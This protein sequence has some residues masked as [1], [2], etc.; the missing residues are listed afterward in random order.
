MSFGTA[1]RT[2]PLW[3][4]LSCTVILL[5]VACKRP[6]LSSFVLSM[7]HHVTRIQIDGR[8]S[9]TPLFLPYLLAPARQ[10]FGMAPRERARDLEKKRDCSQRV[11][12]FVRRKS[13]T[14]NNPS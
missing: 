7:M 9:H 4:A 2:R 10:R 14:G 6:S 13:G 1:L 12:F 8:C 11:H 5:A 3:P